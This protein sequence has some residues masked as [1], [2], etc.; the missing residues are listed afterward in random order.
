MSSNNSKN[1]I[2]QLIK[3]LSWSGQGEAYEGRVK[4]G[5]RNPV[6]DDTQMLLTVLVAAK[7]PK[8]ILELG[9][10]H[11]LSGLCMLRGSATAELV[12][13]EFDEPASKGAQGRFN[14]A[15]VGKRATCHTGDAG[16]AGDAGEVIK[17][18]DQKFD[19]V[20]I[21]HEKSLYLPHLQAAQEGGLLEDG[22]MV[23]GDNVIDREEECKEFV[24]YLQ[25]HATTA[26]IP[27][28]CGLSVSIL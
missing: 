1:K 4:D 16:D 6:R 22:C 27:T 11:G 20:F 17:E 24:D 23:I 7:K 10:A 15:G 12:T 3:Q 5:F 19:M 18:L 9:T 14:E 26:I 8:R 25:E 13:I 2:E 28:E 21:D